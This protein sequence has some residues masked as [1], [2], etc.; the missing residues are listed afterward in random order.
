MA[1][2]TI[3]GENQIAKKQGDRAALNITQFVLAYI[4]DLGDEPVTRMESLPAAEFV[5]DKLDVTK[6]GY[7][8][9]NQVIYSVVM[10]SDLGDYDFNWIGLVDDE[11][12]LIAASYVPTIQKRKTK[13]S[14][15]GNTFTRNFLLKYS[16][17]QRVTA[18]NVPAETWQ[19]DFSQRLR[20]LDERERLLWMDLQGEASFVGDAWKVTRRSVDSFRITPGLGYVGGI[21]VKDFV[22]R[23]LATHALPSTIWLE[24]AQE[25]DLS[26]LETVPRVFFSKYMQY[27]YVDDNN[28]P[29]FFTKLATI[30]KDG[31]VTDMRQ[32]SYQERVA[33]HAEFVASKA[34]DDA[35]DHSDTLSAK[36]LSDA[37][38]HTDSKTSSALSD[39]QKYADNK[40]KSALTDAKQY[41]DSKTS[42]TLSDAQ[43]HADNKTASVLSDAKKHADSKVASALSDARSH[44]DSKSSSALSD[45]KRHADSK[46]SS[47][48][49]DAKKHADSKTASSLSE[50]KSYSETLQVRK[51]L[52]TVAGNA[53]SVTLRSQSGAQPITKLFEYDEFS[54]VVRWTNTG[55]MKIAIDGVGAVS[56]AGV[57]RANQ[58]F[59]TALLT[60]RYLSGQF[61]IVEQINPKTGNSVLDIGK[62]LIDTT[63]IVRPGEY[64]LDGT[65]LSRSEHPIAWAIAKA[66]SNV[67]SQST[68]NSNLDV[69][70]GYYGEGN[71]STTFT[72]PMIG[73]EFIRMA[74]SGRQFGSWQ[75]DELKSH[76]HTTFDMVKSHWQNYA[77]TN[78]AFKSGTTTTGATGGD[79]TRPR[80]IAY[81]GKTRL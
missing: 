15:T 80:N 4:T 1:F 74:G 62:L 51:R 52:F 27:N 31:N 61:V 65:E 59:A 7:V 24:V 39:A 14:S 26:D 13:G 6:N 8:N 68:K 30:D 72:L 35:K 38:Q 58:V 25:G 81:Y 66:T 55:A 63:D 36:T 60:V 32:A 22:N 76:T 45:A 75:A 10:G 23:T 28:V 54:F 44:A 48:L 37:K 70:G 5:V 29:R 17:I 50:A 33:E 79:E 11:G 77:R 71:G 21:R 12:V 67:I 73:G 9:T 34:L 64:V 20:A 69:Y 18:V 49:S 2:I 19:I 40:A 3:E 78:Q 42:S 57:T 43:K 56:V 16:G 53:N 47:A 46:A 41:T